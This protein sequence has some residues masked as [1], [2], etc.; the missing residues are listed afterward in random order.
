MPQ[1]LVVGLL[2]AAAIVIAAL[3][4]LVGVLWSA[5]R[6]FRLGS[7]TAGTQETTVETARIAQLVDENQKARAEVTAEWEVSQKLRQSIKLSDTQHES[8]C[9]AWAAKEKSLLAKIDDLLGE[10]AQFA[11]KLEQVNEEAGVALRA[12][13]RAEGGLQQARRTITQF[14]PS[15]QTSPSN[16]PEDHPAPRI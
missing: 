1:P 14:S 15:S 9:Q 8:E 5:S 16:S 7:R 2:S 12:Q 6:S 13:E 3:L 4:G 11:A 10:S